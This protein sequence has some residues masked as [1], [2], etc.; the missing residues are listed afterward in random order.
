[1]RRVLISWVAEQLRPRSTDPDGALRAGLLNILLLGLVA[2][3]TTLLVVACFAWP[4]GYLTFPDFVLIGAALTLMVIPAWL[5]R[6]G[7]TNLASALL[8]IYL[9]AGVLYV[10]SFKG[11]LTTGILLVG[12]LVVFSALMLGIR[13]A[14][15]MTGAGILLIFGYSYA[16]HQELLIPTMKAT[17][18]PVESL[19]IACELTAMVLMVWL[20]SRQMHSELKSRTRA[21]DLG[22]ERLL[23]LN[24]AS[25]DLQ[26]AREPADVYRIVGDGVASLGGIVNILV[27]DEDRTGLKMSYFSMA[28]ALVRKAEKLSG[29]RAEGFAFPM[30]PGGAIERVVNGGEPAILDST[31]ELFCEAMPEKLQPLAGP[32]VRLL[33]ME[34]GIMVPVR[35]DDQPFGLLAITGRDFRQE[36]LP[37]L[38]TFANQ[39]ARAL[40]SLRFQEQ[41]T[42]AK[43]AAEAANLAKSRFLANMSHELRTPLNAILGFSKMMRDGEFG[44]I[45]GEQ[46]ETLDDILGSTEHLRELI[47][48]VLNISKIEAGK[49]ELDVSMVEVTEVLAGSLKMIQ[50]QAD[51][52]GINVEYLPASSVA[53]LRIPA[54][55]RK[56]KQIIYNLLSNAAKFTPGGGTITLQ[57]RVVGDELMISVLDTGPGVPTQERDK[58]FDVFYQIDR[59]RYSKA[60]GTGLGLPLTKQMIEL[61]GGQIRVARVEGG[62]GSEFTFSMPLT[63]EHSPQTP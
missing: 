8:N 51:E 42:K 22:H 50:T 36:D 53:D 3:N 60:P 5:A 49:M 31:T 11:V 48:D 2:L 6:R 4:A 21:R 37:A 44:E 46:E 29:V 54:D 57:A 24:K 58:I 20:S 35:V 59:G 56:F 19:I 47:D 9:T 40:A 61:H 33:G 62:M 43:D 38:Q 17:E 39:T 18:F 28:P 1:M 7:K 32:L 45:N 12:L 27:L 10:F 26:S 55:E 63:I 14:F 25:I 30:Q 34:T 15:A 23:A 52:Q 41:L 16:Y 13:A